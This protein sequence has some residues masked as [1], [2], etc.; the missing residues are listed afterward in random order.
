MIDQ[1]CRGSTL[2]PGTVGQAYGQNFFV[3]GG[4]APY[5]WSVPPGQLPPGLH[6]QTFNDPRDAN[7]ELAG[8]PTTPGTFTFTMQVTD[9][10]GH[11]A[12]Q[13]F[14]L[15]SQPPL[16]IT[17]PRMPAGRVGVPNN[18]DFTAQGGVPPFS[19]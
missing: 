4:A 13:Q 17:R 11:Q 18:N 9:F 10:Y 15:Q 6:L 14:T 16:Q 19:L 12:T 7:N 2:G 8:T 3:S 1:P 5:T